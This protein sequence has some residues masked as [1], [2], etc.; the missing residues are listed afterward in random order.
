[1]QKYFAW[2]FFLAVGAIVVWA[3]SRGSADQADYPVC[4]NEQLAY[5]EAL[6]LV[7]SE[8]RSPSTAVFPGL[9]DP[10]TSSIPV[11][12]GSR[13]PP[14]EFLVSGYVDAQNGFGAMI[15]QNFHAT[16]VYTGDGQWQIAEPILF[17]TN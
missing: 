3:I 8:L 15:R 7:R 10:G 4:E 12:S 6:D 9:R 2:A 17:T 1:M 11:V 13:V 16:V 14:C 5:R